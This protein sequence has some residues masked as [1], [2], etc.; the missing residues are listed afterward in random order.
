MGP[1]GA[2]ALSSLGI[3]QPGPRGTTTYRKPRLRRGQGFAQAERTPLTDALSRKW[4]P[5]VLQLPFL[6]PASPGPPLQPTR[7]TDG[8]RLIFRVPGC[9]SLKRVL[10]RRR[11]VRVNHTVGPA[12]FTQNGS[13]FHTGCADNKC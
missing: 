3:L 9:L 13:P 6:L 11:V 7:V 2:P 10:T 12:V 8:R 4:A 1:R 5:L